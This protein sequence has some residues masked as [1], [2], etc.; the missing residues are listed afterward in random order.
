MFDCAIQTE[1]GS[2]SYEYLTSVQERFMGLF[3]DEIPE[4][5]RKHEEMKTPNC[6]SDKLET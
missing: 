4:L 6:S 3:Q 5:R 1:S 2:N